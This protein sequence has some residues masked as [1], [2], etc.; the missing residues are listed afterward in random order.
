MHAILSFA[1]VLDYAFGKDELINDILGDVA[2][3]QFRL[4]YSMWFPTH[5]EHVY[6]YAE[7]RLSRYLSWRALGPSLAQTEPSV[8]R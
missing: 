6:A 4:P 5:A 3:V 1:D 2:T 7:S 8:C